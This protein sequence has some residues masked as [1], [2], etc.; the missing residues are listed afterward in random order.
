MKHTR[1]IISLVLIYLSQQVICFDLWAENR[2]A[3]RAEAFDEFLAERARDP[4][5]KVM[6]Y[7]FMKGRYHPGSINDAGMDELT[8]E[9]IVY[10]IALN[11]Q[12]QNFLPDPKPGASDL[13]IVVHYGR[14]HPQD[15]SLM[16]MMGYTSLE[17]MD[18]ALPDTSGIPR[19]ISQELEFNANARISIDQA[20]ENNA[21]YK[22]QLLGMEEAY[23]F[24]GTERDE[25]LLKRLINE[26][27]Y[28]VVL[29]AYDYQEMQKGE[30][31]LLWRTR[32]SVR[33]IGQSFTQAVGNMNFVA[34][35]YFGKNMKT[36]I[37]RRP[38]DTSEVK[39][40]DIEVIETDEDPSAN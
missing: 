1:K 15:D 29:M 34:S 24:K 7:Q 20:N 18:S 27:R 5:K 4:S 25:R 2:V 36:L 9:E 40:G 22:A 38:S 13:L 10:D 32:Y 31:V 19:S 11:L 3:V 30:I 8:F 16:E 17:E 26:E 33:A 6:T 14:T 21:Y 23:S 28:F 39:I 12:K 35:N 37:N